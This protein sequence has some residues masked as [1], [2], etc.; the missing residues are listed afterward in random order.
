[1]LALRIKQI[2]ELGC[3]II[4]LL[5]KKYLPELQYFTNYLHF[6]VVQRKLTYTR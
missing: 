2:N 4:D 1:M 6:Y 3:A 5:E